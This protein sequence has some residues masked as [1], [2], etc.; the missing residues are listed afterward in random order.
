MATG[1]QCRQCSGQGHPCRA[2]VM[3]ILRQRRGLRQQ[4]AGLDSHTCLGWVQVGL[5]VG[6]EGQRVGLC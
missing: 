1:Q 3:P 6:V 4:Q 5:G 2:L